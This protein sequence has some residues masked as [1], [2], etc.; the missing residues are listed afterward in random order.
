MTFYDEYY[1]KNKLDENSPYSRYEKKD[2]VDEAYWKY[3]SITLLYENNQIKYAL[4][5]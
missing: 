5:S 4:I 1:D 3:Y 2:L